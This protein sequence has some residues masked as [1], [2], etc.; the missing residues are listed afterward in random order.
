MK[1][2][3]KRNPAAPPTSKDGMPGTGTGTSAGPAAEA[4][5]WAVILAG[6]SGTRFWPKSRHHRPKQLMAIGTSDKTL[7]ETTLERLTDFIPPERRI[8]VTHRD[9]MAAT[10]ALA[11]GRCG[12]FLAEPE[13]RN[14]ANALGLAALEIRERQRRLT[15]AAS[16]SPVMISL[17]ADHVIKDE[18]GFRA[19]LRS[20]IA[21][22]RT[23]RLTLVGVVPDRPET[24]FGYIERAAPLAEAAGAFSVKAFREKPDLDT[25]KAYVASGRFYWNAGLFVWR[26]EDL[27]AELTAK[28][29]ATVAALAQ[30]Q[31][32]GGGTF[33]DGDRSQLAEVYRSL[34][35][36]SIDHAV[37][38]TSSNLAVVPADI[39][40]Q[41][42]GTWDAVERAVTP[43]AA[44]NLA[45]GD[46]CLLGTKNSLVESDG[47][48]VAA[49]GVSDLVVVASGGA[50]LVCPKS[51]AQD[52][53]EIVNW[54][55]T[56]GRRELV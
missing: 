51:R 39:G 55:T 32:K 24:G 3:S 44:G 40:W 42:V 43:D 29:P 9:Q 41:D 22:A 54:L 1:H 47:P 12:I 35:K 30:A 46:V 14:T 49:L 10:R 16:P 23:G 53:K 26:V 2:Q 52:V 13:A 18:A 11:A 38:E 5:V 7:L 36:I 21:V 31:A 34:P 27:L 45:F 8:L 19:V 6:G 15:G 28:L 25:A 56:N 4:D 50:V 20:A 37:L 48:F 17:H 33:V